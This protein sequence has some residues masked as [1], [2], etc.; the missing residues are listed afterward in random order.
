MGSFEYYH[1]SFSYTLQETGEEKFVGV[2]EQG[3]RDL[4]SADPLAAWHRLQRRRDV[5]RHGRALPRRGL[6]SRAARASSRLAGGV[7]G[8][9]KES[10]QRA[11]SYLQAKKTELGIA[12][13]LDVSDLHVE[14]ID[15]LGQP[16]RGRARRRV[17]RRLLLGAAEGARQ[18]GAARPRRHERPGEH[19]AAALAHRAAAGREGTTARSARSSR[20]RTS[21]TS[22]TSAPTSW[23]TSTRSSTAIRRRRR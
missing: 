21:G 15:L 11:F 20:S 10:V 16:R 22:S 4:I 7:A 18:P 3:G 19:Q 5:G 13:D 1:T 17:L 9:M 6:A 12:R 23:S 14:V 8:A 2:P